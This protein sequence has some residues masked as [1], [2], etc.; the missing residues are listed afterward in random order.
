MLTTAQAKAQLRDILD[1]RYP[2]L[3]TKKPGERVLLAMSVLANDLKVREKGGNNKGEWVQA[4]GGAAGFGTGGGFAWC[5]ISIEFCC[6]VVGVEL[7]P[8]DPD[9][10]RVAQW[11]NWA[12]KAGRLSSTPARG[13][14]CL[15]VNPDGTGHIGIVAEVKPNGTLRT[16][17]G[18]TSSGVSGSQRDGD[19]LYERT[20]GA[21]VFQR[22]IDL[23]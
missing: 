18:N 11:R 13:R 6:E 2:D 21:G 23:N 14:L 5:A 19:G 15:W 7:G 16:Y 9:S 3:M 1:R 4:M 10:G 17:E 22:F 20:R 12:S 8:K